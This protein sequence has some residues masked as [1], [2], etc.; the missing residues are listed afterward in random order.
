MSKARGLIRRKTPAWDLYRDGVSYSDISRWLGNCRERFRLHKV[1]G[2]REVS[3]TEALDFG[4]YFHSLL[5]YGCRK[6]IQLPALKAWF[7]KNVGTEIDDRELAMVTWLMF[8]FY[9]ARWEGNS[10]KRDYFA[11]EE[12]FRFTIKLPSGRS[13]ILK[14]RYDQLYRENGR[15]W[16][17]ENKTKSRYNE[18]VIAQT[19]FMD[20]QTMIY[21]LAIRKTMNV[22]PEGVLYNVIRKPGIRRKV[23]EPIQEYL[24]RLNK[25]V[26]S[27]ESHYF[28]RI[29]NRILPGDIDSFCKTILYPI[30]E[31]MCIWWESIK[32]D[33]FQPWTLPDGSAN[34]HH[35]LKPFGVFDEFSN[36]RGP[37]YNLVAL[38]SFAGLEVLGDD[39]LERESF[40][41]FDDE[42]DGEE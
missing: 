28:S 10:L 24:D 25:D 31:Q 41:N 32:A 38:H 40:G 6:E 39:R 36:G 35:F 16:I 13:V 4:N 26:K 1:E 19:L 7:F 5:Q 27:Q 2:F 20:L 29:R 11:S 15:I 14:G 3:G 9:H 33:P 21:A 18:D 8:T 12:S 22:D 37:F 30:L 42:E 17:Q 23:R 34:P